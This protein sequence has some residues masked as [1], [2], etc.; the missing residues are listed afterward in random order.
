MAENSKIGW[1]DHTFNPVIGCQKVG[2]GCD[3]CYAE[4]FT[5][6]TGMVE[7]GPGQ[8]RHVTSDEN[9]KQPRRWDR[10]AELAGKPAKVFCASMADVFD[11][12]WRQ[13]V[14]PALW[15]LIRD[16]PNLIWLLLTKRVGNIPDML[17]PDW[18][19]GYPNVCL[20]ITV[21]T[22]GEADR[23]I[24]KLIEIPARWHALS[25]EPLLEPVRLGQWLLD[26]DWVIVG[27]ESG[28]KA[29]PYGFRWPK[30]IIDE[31]ETA[32]V[33][34]FHKQAGSNPYW[35]DGEP[36]KLDHRKGE[37]PGEWPIQLRVQQFPEG[38]PA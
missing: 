13:G 5:K 25:M 15:S 18:G 14:R 9:W 19:A 11:N 28:P 4:A 36:I 12:A 23:D 21:V 6:R 38:M 35:F 2:P 22:Q 26:L 33:A 27:G 37:D 16:T 7:W 34:V 10:K 30:E 29:R 24:P 8:E 1:T 20:M 32:G 17:P 3:N 31:C